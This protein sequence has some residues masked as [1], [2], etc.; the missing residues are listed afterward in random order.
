[1]SRPRQ[2]TTDQEYRGFP[3]IEGRDDLQVRIEVPLLVRALNL[4]TGGRV[5]ETGCGSVTSPSTSSSISARVITSPVLRSRCKKSLECCVPEVCSFTRRE[6]VSSLRTRCARSGECY[7][8]SP[9]RHCVGIGWLSFGRRGKK[10][11]IG[12]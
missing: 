4:P 7:P 6:S 9:R 10:T 8:G 1:M 5:L 11:A 2:A 3:E 12:H